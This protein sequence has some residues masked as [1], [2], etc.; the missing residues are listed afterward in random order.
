MYKAIE[1]LK[2]LKVKIPINRSLRSKDQTIDSSRERHL[3]GLHNSN[4]DLK[5]ELV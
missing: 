5:M 3:S 2:N 1:S 4:S